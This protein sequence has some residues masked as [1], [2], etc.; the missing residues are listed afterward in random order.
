MEGFY[1]YTTESQVCMKITKGKPPFYNIT[2]DMVAG[3]NDE[4]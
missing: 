3:E 2:W 4:K 1:T